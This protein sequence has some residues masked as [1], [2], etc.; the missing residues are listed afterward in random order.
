MC[1][2][3]RL[4][5]CNFLYEMLTGLHMLDAWERVAFNSTVLALLGVILYFFFGPSGR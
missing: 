5:R 4:R 3:A 1:T 2:C